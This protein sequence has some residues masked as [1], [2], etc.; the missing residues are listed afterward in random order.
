M[1]DL[2]NGVFAPALTVP[3]N[4]NGSTSPCNAG[5]VSS[6]YRAATVQV[7]N[8]FRAMTGLPADLTELTGASTSP[9][10]RP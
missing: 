3:G 8:Y 10:R 6:A 4:W 7:L 5:T 2:Y 9:R 1:V